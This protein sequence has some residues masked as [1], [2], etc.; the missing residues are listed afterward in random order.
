MEEADENI[1]RVLE[2]LSVTSSDHVVVGIEHYHASPPIEAQALLHHRLILDRHY[3][4][5]MHH[6]IHHHIEQGQ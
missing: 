6:I 2:P 3:H 1:E 5:H 4:P